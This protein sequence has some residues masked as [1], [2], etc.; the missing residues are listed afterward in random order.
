MSDEEESEHDPGGTSRKPVNWDAV[1]ALVAVVIALLATL[2][3]AYAA[4][5]Q[6]QQTRAQVWPHLIIGAVG[7]LQGETGNSSH[8]GGL[9]VDSGGVGPAI[10]SRVEVLVD[11]K[12]AADWHH[13]FE[14]LGYPSGKPDATAGALAHDVFPP[15]RQKY[16]LTV[17]G[18]EEWLSLKDK[19]VDHVVIHV[20]YRSALG[21]HWMTTM[22]HSGVSTNNH[23]VGSCSEIAE[24]DEFNG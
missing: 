16:I 15:G 21:E 11:G 17:F 8:G 23:P 14:A 3:S 5:E 4:W 6:R 12:P 18:H 24:K 9:M 7:V 13:V 20:C 2:V 19:I 1:T 10:V 22:K